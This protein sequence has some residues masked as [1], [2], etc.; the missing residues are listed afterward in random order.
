MQHLRAGKNE[1]K[2]VWFDV[3]ESFCPKITGEVYREVN[4]AV[5]R[6]SFNLKLMSFTNFSGKSTE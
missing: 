5:I 4:T 6:D 1:K 2:W 3:K